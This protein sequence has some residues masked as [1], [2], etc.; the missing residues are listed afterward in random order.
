FSQ[1]LNQTEQLQPLLKRLPVIVNF[2]LIIACAQLLSEAIWMLLDDSRSESVA[3][4]TPANSVTSKNL[5]NAK[6]SQQQAFR[7][8]TSSH[9]FGIAET[10]KAPITA[11][12]APET[13][14]NLVLKGVLAA[15]TTPMASAIIAQSA[16]GKEEIYGIGDKIPGGIT[17]KEIHPEHVIL[18]RRGQLE[19]LRMLKDK[20][21]AQFSP[22]SNAAQPST[23]LIST[24]STKKLKKIRNELIKNPK[25]FQNYALPIVVRENGKQIGFRLQPKQNSDLLT[26][27]G[28]EPSD[29]I[30]SINGIKLNDMTNSISALNAL[31]T[32][33]SVNIM[34]KRNGVE[35]PL[36]IQLQ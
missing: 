20:G 13:K 15:G 25:S 9:L 4:V 1:L 28:I 17:L 14:L 6:K 19:T 30:T 8:L 29:V 3:V 22:V 31:R 24:A 26:Q 18:E 32:A 11:S 7:K 10:K 27:A 2:V 16:N 36:N 12:V 35:V 23:S 34:V 33:N 5:S 21:N